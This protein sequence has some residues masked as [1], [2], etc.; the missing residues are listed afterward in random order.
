MGSTFT[1]TV[2]SG[3]SHF[4]RRMTDYPLVFEKAVGC[5][6]HPG[7]I[8]ILIR[9]QIRIRE[10]FRIRG[11][12]IGEPGQDL[13]F[14]KCLINGTP[15]FRIRPTSISNPEQ[16]G[17]GDHV[18]EI[19]SCEQIPNIAPGVVVTIEFFRDVEADV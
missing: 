4:S 6:L 9:R 2:Q 10:E 17:H 12:D 15:A 11:V 5:R 14:E 8:N 1:G 19:S 18:L 7:T 13:Q 16:G 3:C